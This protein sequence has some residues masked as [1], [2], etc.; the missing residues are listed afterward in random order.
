V[1]A[2]Q[3]RDGLRPLLPSTG[4]KQVEHA[5]APDASAGGDP[6]R[7]MASPGTSSHGRGRKWRDEEGVSEVRT[8]FNR[9]RNGQLEGKSPFYSPN[10]LLCS[11]T[12]LNKILA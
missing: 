7:S 4:S 12:F 9:G 11:V 6:S 8:K 5:A 3:L 10:N 2:L 1:A